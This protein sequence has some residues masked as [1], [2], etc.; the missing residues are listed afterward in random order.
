M[1]SAFIFQQVEKCDNSTIPG[2]GFPSNSKT[3]KL[4][5]E[6]H[7]QPDY[8]AYTALSV[9]QSILKNGAII[10]AHSDVRK[11]GGDC[12]WGFHTNVKLLLIVISFVLQYICIYM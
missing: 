11:F 9:V 7:N 3:L 12:N 2:V 5:K 6:D 4:L 8:E 10:D 1:S